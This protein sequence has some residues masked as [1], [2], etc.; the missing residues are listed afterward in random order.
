MLR[1]RH[2][3]AAADAALRHYAC[4][5]LLLML[6]RFTTTPQPAATYYANMILMLPL[7]PPPIMLIRLRAALLPPFRCR[8]RLS[9]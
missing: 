9:H 8:L 1:C 4:R 7:M 5:H 2:A 6:M 3:D